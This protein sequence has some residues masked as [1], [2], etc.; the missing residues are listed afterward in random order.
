MP[1]VLSREIP[2]VPGDVLK[3]CVDRAFSLVSSKITNAAGDRTNLKMIGRLVTGTPGAFVLSLAGTEANITG[4]IVG[5]VNKAVLAS[6]LGS[7]VT[8]D[9]YAV[10]YRGPALYDNLIATDPADAAYT[11]ATVR[12]ALTARNIIE[13][14]NPPVTGTQDT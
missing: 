3:Y 8:V 6:L 9:E 13:V 5:P 1:T 4:I 14:E 11:M 2:V 7:A 12:T 10:L